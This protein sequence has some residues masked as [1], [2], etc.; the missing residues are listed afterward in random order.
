MTSLHIRLLLVEDN[1]G[2]A[3]LIR[4]FLAEAKGMSFDLEWVE[5][6]ADAVKRLA[7]GGIDL[8]L[9]DLE[10]PD[11]TGLETLRRVHAASPK[12]VVVV[13]LSGLKD[14]EVSV[15]AVQQGGQDY[16]I[17][18]QVDSSILAR[19]IR[20]ALERGQAQEALRLAYADLENRVRERTA[21]LIKANEALRNSQHLVQSILDHSTAVIF[22]KDIEGRYM[23][24][25]NRY[26]K[27]FHIGREAIIGKTDYD[28]FP[29][30][31]ADALVAAD[32]QAVATGLAQELEELVP[33]DDGVHTYI[34]IK[35]P[36]LDGEGRPYALCGIATDITEWKRMQEQ[37]RQSQ[38]MEAIGRLAGGVAH[39]F[40][41]LLS[42]I[43]GFTEF[44]RSGLRGKPEQAEHVEQIARAAQQAAALTR[45][46]LT[47]SRRQMPQH[48]VL[49][50]NAVLH[51]LEKDPAKRGE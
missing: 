24:I 9:L 31:Y 21:E 17:K 20:Y 32:Q 51:D 43:I 35:A 14:E 33:H 1:P 48:Q 45:K 25:N 36:L 44:L 50:L 29:K 38:K 5:T 23:L 37:L 46:L 18:G 4:A 2:D 7:K 40:N 6:L 47:F 41:N 13:V 15:Q 34:A 22:V 8:V 19:S 11:C 39:D 28:L 27:L 12:A 10:L 26:E 49:D 3:G 42:V 16:L 30:E